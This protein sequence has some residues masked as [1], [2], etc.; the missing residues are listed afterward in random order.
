VNGDATLVARLSEVALE[1]AADRVAETSVPDNT[2]AEEGR[3]SLAIRTE[4]ERATHRGTHTR[5]THPR[6]SLP[7][8]K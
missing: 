8:G 1:H 2:I 4:T 6:V 5:Q 7:V 3:L